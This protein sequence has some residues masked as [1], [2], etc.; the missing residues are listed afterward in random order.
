MTLT[1][2]NI[3]EQAIKLYKEKKIGGVREST[4]MKLVSFFQNKLD[5]NN[6]IEILLRNKLEELLYLLFI[7]TTLPWQIRK[8]TIVAAFCTSLS[9]DELAVTLKIWYHK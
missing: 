3:F 2:A 8:T 9:L 5:F 6:I 1:L 4:I 7:E